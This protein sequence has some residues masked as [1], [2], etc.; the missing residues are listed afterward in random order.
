MVKGML[1]QM[2]YPYLDL[3][4]VVEEHTAVIVAPL[5]NQVPLSQVAILYNNDHISYRASVAPT[6]TISKPPETPAPS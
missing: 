1:D 2:D 6:I 4:E 3:L 5:L